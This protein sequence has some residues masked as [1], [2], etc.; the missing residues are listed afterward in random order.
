[1]LTLLAL[2]LAGLAAACS[3][4]TASL[5]VG[6]APDVT[7]TLAPVAT[8]VGEPPHLVIAQRAAQVGLR[9]TGELGEIDHLTAEVAPIAAPDDARRW[10]VDVAPA[11]ADG[12]RGMVTLPSHALSSGAY[13]LTLWEGDAR[14]VGRFAFRVQKGP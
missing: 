9:L 5:P 8:S 10:R 4:D 14:I 1:M 6:L 12:A 11:G 13:V 7:V 3:S 2:V